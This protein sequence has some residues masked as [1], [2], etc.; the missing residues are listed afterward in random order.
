MKYSKKYALI[1]DFDGTIT[2][3]DVGDFILLKFKLISK[4]E[5][6]LGYLTDM[7]VE[8]WMKKHFAAA[9]KIKKEKIEK[10]VVSQIKLRPYFKKTAEF[11]RK[12]LIPLEIVSGGVDL[13]AD[14]ILKFHK[15]KVKSF[16]G[17]FK[18]KNN[19]VS[20]TYPYL[21]NKTLSEFK[22]S[23]VEYYKKRGYSVIF[24][25]DAP[26]DL[27]AAKT[28]DTAFACRF[29][30]ALLKKE[31]KSYKRLKDFSEIFKILKKSATLY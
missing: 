18:V 20:I 7:P 6:D 19:S 9:A 2:E 10:A 17:K 24:C 29:L 12:N 1:T 8:D 14:P 27:P 11:C 25:G 28:A 23:R 26:N 3:R 30:P 5:I 22:K 15:L 4:K 31:K 13:Y 16:F 21:K